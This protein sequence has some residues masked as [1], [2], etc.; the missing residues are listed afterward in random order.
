MIAAENSTAFHL[1]RIRW[2]AVNR[3]RQRVS[4]QIF[5]LWQKSLADFLNGDPFAVINAMRITYVEV[6]GRFAR[7]MFKKVSQQKALGDITDP[8]DEQLALFAR[9]EMGSITQSIQDTTA[10]LSAKILA[11]ESLSAAETIEE[12]DRMIIARAKIVTQN[13][14]VRASN[15]GQDMGADAAVRVDASRYVKTWIATIDDR[16]RDG[17]DNADGQSVRGQEDFI[18][19]GEALKYPK[20]PAGSVGNTINCRC[21]LDYQKIV[22]S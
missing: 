22:E 15:V 18:V 9:D 10:S 2:K 17:H 5:K 1:R 6:G 8:F 21:V 16:V 11:D 12:I 14:I 7:N 3:A 13:E 20:D 19:A 4:F